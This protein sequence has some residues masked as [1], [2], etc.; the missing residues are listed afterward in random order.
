MKAKTIVESEAWQVSVAGDKTFFVSK[1]GITY[2]VKQGELEDM[3]RNPDKYK[4]L[5]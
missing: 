1:K 4:S 2:H 3:L 5:G